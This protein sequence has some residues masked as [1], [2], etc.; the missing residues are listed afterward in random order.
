MFCNFLTNDDLKELSGK[1]KHKS[2]TKGLTVLE[3]GT[4][5]NYI[6]NIIEGN[7]KIY[8]LDS[9]GE[10]HILGFLYPTNFFGSHEGRKYEYYAETIG[11]VLLCQIPINEFHLFLQNNPKIKES[12][13]QT[14]INELRLARIQ[15]GLLSKTTAEERVTRFL[16]IIADK[17]KS[18]GQPMNPVILPMKR[19]DIANYLGLTTET[20]S[21][22][23]SKLRGKHLIRYI[24]MKCIELGNHLLN[25]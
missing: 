8:Q 14:A 3:K 18:Y 22:V 25:Q 9:N 15:I 11:H 19:L 17:Q 1:V 6:Y 21:R 23:F 2:Y 16:Q 10:V 12:F 5:V 24:D 13:Y 20:V 4:D 7:I